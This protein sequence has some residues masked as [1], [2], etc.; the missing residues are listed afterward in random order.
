MRIGINLI[1]YSGIQG[2]EVFAANIIRELIALDKNEIILFT[3]QRS[4]VIFN[5][6]GSNVR[7]V[8]K[9]FSSLSRVRFIVYQQFGFRR[10]LKENRIDILF[11]PSVAI[12]LFYRKAVVTVPDVAFRRFKE[13]AS[14]F[15]SLYL[16]VALFSA[17]YFSKKI[18]AV[19]NFSRSELVDLFHIRPEKITVIYPGVPLLPEV[20][21]QDALLKKFN[22]DGLYF[23]YVGISRPRKNILGL[24]DAFA[25]FRKDHA[26]YKLLLAGAIDTSFINV[27]AAIQERGMGDHI[28]Q[29]GFISA[30]E[31]VALLRGARALVFPSYYEGFGL[32]VLEAQSEG[33]PVLTSTVSSLPEVAGDSA[34]LVDPYDV[35]DIAHG[36]GSLASDV[37]LREE[38]IRKGYENLK[39]F[40]GQDTAR[41]LIEVFES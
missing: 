23:L 15:S 35:E 16:R 17:K 30:E 37:N 26:D 29:A 7:V 4:S 33:T 25:T 22:I 19:S 27:A 1:Q 6:S 31:K 11:C 40:S 2:L 3:N 20:R 41:K 21:D 12:P 9:K 14:F 5:F 18:I 39:R 32:P 13:E 36:M 24:I 34:L 28:I 38:L 10:A 8:E